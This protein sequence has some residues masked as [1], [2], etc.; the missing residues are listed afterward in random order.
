[1]GDF[2]KEIDLLEPW[3]INISIKRLVPRFMSGS[4]DR[5]ADGGGEDEL[6]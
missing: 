3:E 4:M 1:M 2:T 5:D 6:A